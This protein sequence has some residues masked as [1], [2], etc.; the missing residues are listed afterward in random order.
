MLTGHSHPSLIFMSNFTNIFNKLGCLSHFKPS[1]IFVFAVQTEAYQV[2][3]SWVG[4]YPYLKHK[5]RLERLVRDKT[6]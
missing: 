5:T 1:Q 3:H 2:L 4:S 6:L